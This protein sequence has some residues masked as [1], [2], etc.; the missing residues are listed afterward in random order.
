M[1]FLS[2]VSVAKLRFVLV[3]FLLTTDVFLN[4]LVWHEHPLSMFESSRRKHLCAVR[5]HTN[6]HF[7]TFTAFLVRGQFVSRITGTFEAS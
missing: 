5:G 7:L 6:T 3:V 4:C 2:R 1:W